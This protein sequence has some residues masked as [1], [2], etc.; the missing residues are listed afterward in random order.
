MPGH[1]GG[2]NWGSSAVNPTKGIFFVVSKELPVYWQSCAGHSDRTGRGGGR[3][4][5][6]PAAA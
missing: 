4:G 5:A 3:A 2:A 1:N 6:P